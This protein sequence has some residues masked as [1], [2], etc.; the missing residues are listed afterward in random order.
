MAGERAGAVEYAGDNLED[1]GLA[2]ATLAHA[3]CGLGNGPDQRL[4]PPPDVAAAVTRAVLGGSG[5]FFTDF[6]IRNVPGGH[7]SY[8]IHVE[9]V[10]RTVNY[11]TAQ[12]GKRISLSIGGG[13]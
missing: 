12:L 4:C 3:R 5:D 11:T 10:P 6:T 7:D 1:D 2:V 13:G 9:G 8:G